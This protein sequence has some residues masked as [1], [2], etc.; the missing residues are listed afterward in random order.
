M[1]A[2]PIME[3]ALKYVSMLLDNYTPV[4]V[5]LGIVFTIMECLVMVCVH[6]YTVYY[7]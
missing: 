6:V 3:A 7:Y 4:G 1:N 5:I 2:P